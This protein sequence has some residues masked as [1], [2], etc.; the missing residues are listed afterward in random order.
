MNII[1][2]GLLM[3]LIMNLGVSFHPHVQYVVSRGVFMFF[4]HMHW[5]GERNQEL[6]CDGDCANI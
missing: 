5:H 6:G 1:P 2:S 4:L 3:C